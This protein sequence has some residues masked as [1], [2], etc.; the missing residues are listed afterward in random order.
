[1]ELYRYIAGDYV[2]GVAERVESL[3][4]I[5]GCC[6]SPASGHY[7]QVTRYTGAEALSGAVL[8]I[9]QLNVRCLV[10][11]PVFHLFFHSLAYSELVPQALFRSNPNAKILF[12]RLSG[13]A[14]PERGMHR[15]ISH[16]SFF[17]L[18]VKW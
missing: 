15:F 17:R 12:L 3:L 14:Q 11:V 5:A 8:D 1:L 9:Q 10:F 2:A 6:I 16:F 7:H 18:F 13:L 4:P